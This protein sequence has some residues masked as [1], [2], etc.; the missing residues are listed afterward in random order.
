LFFFFQA[1][2]GIRYRDVTGVQTCALPIW[3][4]GATR[5]RRRGRATPRRSARLRSELR[6]GADRGVEVVR[7]RRHARGG[8]ADRGVAV[9]R[10]APVRDQGGRAR[11]RKRRV[12]LSR[13][14]RAGRRL[15]GG[16]V[17]R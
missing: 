6:S 9:G 10:T 17:L 8:R 2:D 4:G 13:P 16:N 5:G 7:E 12:H 11:G 14:G 15:A 1:E 3:P